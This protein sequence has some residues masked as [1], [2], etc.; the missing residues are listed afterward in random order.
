MRRGRRSSKTFSRMKTSRAGISADRRHGLAVCKA[1]AGPGARLSLHRRSGQVSL[2]NVVASGVAAKYRSNRR[3]D[4][5]GATLPRCTPGRSGLSALEFALGAN[6]TVPPSSASSSTA[7]GVCI[8]ISVASFRT[9]SMT[10][11]SF[12]IL[13]TEGKSSYSA[14]IQTKCLRRLGFDLS[15]PPTLTVASRARLKQSVWP[16]CMTP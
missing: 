10:A 12:P 4:A 13:P 9:L 14:P 3:P 7:R 15:K 11:V 1:G 8:R 2:A 5:A 6:A 16:R